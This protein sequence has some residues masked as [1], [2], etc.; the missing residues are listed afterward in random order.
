M[1]NRMEYVLLCSAEAAVSVGGTALFRLAAKEIEKPFPRNV[2]A[3]MT[4]LNLILAFIWALYYKEELP[5]ILKASTIVVILW[6]CAWTDYRRYLILNRIL[7]LGLML[8]LVWGLADFLIYS[9]EDF[10][11]ILASALIAGGMLGA[12]SLLCR[13]LSPQ[14]VG[15]G[16]IKL[17]ILFG[18]YTGVDLAAGSLIYTFLILF[19]VSAVLLILKKADR[20]TV[21]PFAPFLLAGTAVSS[22]LSG[23]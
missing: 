13:V 3:A 17:L 10:L 18:L 16:D 8:R 11:F 4:A 2:C 5:V 1:E 20:K 19:F 12:A 21:I 7:V 9:R 22:F 23:L 14:A 15:F 6:V